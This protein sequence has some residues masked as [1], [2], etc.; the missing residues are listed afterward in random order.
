MAIVGILCQ[1]LFA[2]AIIY[3]A[4]RF[5]KKA[6]VTG[7]IKEKKFEMDLQSSAYKK[8][9]ADVSDEN[10]EQVKRDREGL[11]KFNSL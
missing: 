9:A 1:V 4:V 8:V 11:E 5:F 6:S 3:Y 7:D 2:L 10:I